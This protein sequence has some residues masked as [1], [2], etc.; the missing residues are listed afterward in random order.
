[1]Y[2]HLDKRLCNEF[3]L[4]QHISGNIPDRIS[5]GVKRLAPEPHTMFFK[6][7]QQTG[8]EDIFIAAEQ[9]RYH[10]LPAHQMHY[11]CLKNLIPEKE[12]D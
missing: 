8:V 4:N 3:T 10:K 12:E 5:S 9:T 2:F 11:K 1:M 6:S 7:I